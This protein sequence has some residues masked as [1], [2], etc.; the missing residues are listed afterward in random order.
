MRE[1]PRGELRAVVRVDHDLAVVYSPLLSVPFR[2]DLERRGFS[3]VE[4]PEEEFTT[5]GANVLAV[6]PRR[7]VMLEN[8]PKTRRGLE[9]SG[10]HV[11]TYRG[12]EIS[13]K[14]EGGPTCLTRPL[15]RG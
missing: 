7:C 11:E 13:H 15:R 14:A 2:T 10:C 3:F 12:N 5:M 9:E 1:G 4:V 6:A 8:N